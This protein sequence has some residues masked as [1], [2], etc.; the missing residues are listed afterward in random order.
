MHWSRSHVDSMLALRNIACNQR[1]PQAWPQIT[2]TLRQQAR[3]Q[4]AQRR[5]QR[6]SPVPTAP[7]PS[8][9]ARPLLDPPI[10]SPKP[11]PSPPT[12]SPPSSQPRRPSADHPWRR[13]PI[14]RARFTSPTPHAKS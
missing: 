4:A 9:D 3:H 5:R 11:P 10:R 6:H 12:I 7:F 13:M 2:A 8:V 1:W 14:G